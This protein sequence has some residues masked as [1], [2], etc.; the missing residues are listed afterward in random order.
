MSKWEG[1]VKTFCEPFPAI[2]VNDGMLMVQLCQAMLKGKT[3]ITQ[4]QL[5][6]AKRHSKQ[7]GNWIAVKGYGYGW[8]DVYTT[9]LFG[10]HHFGNRRNFMNLHF[11]VSLL[12]R[13]RYVAQGR[14]VE[15]VK[16]SAY[17]T[18]GRANRR[19]EISIRERRPF[20]ENVRFSG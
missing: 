18:M 14:W 6:F 4:Y 20:W 9:K 15:R 12:C 19:R 13:G 16:K 1:K 11:P 17:R 3:K 2:K 8:R 5:V 10:I 7:K